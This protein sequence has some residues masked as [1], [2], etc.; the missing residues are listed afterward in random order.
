M[1]LEISGLN[2][3]FGEKHALRDVNLAIRRGSDEELGLAP[4]PIYTP[5]H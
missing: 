4:A 3:R 5:G 1:L 2:Q